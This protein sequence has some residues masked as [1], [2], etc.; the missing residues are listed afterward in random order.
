M[1]TKSVVSKGGNIPLVP[2]ENAQYASLFSIEANLYEVRLKFTGA[3]TT[4]T[5]IIPPPLAREVA[6][7][8][9]NVAAAYEEK[10]G[11]PK[12]APALAPE[13]TS[14]APG[15]ELATAAPVAVAA[16]DKGSGLAP[17]V[18]SAPSPRMALADMRN[19]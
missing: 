15:G 17:P 16:Q 3:G 1:E 5:L 10:F 19:K 14:P 18:N 11:M 8:L 7:S 2:M 6:Q 4:A 13:K 12:L 9:W